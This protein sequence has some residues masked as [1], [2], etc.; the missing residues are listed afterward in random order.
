MVVRWV[1]APTCN[2]PAGRTTEPVSLLRRTGIETVLLRPCGSHGVVIAS[3]GSQPK[4]SMLLAVTIPMHMRRGGWQNAAVRRLRVRPGEPGCI[5][6]LA[7]LARSPAR[8]GVQRIHSSVRDGFSPAL[9]F[10]EFR[11][12]NDPFD[13]D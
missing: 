11:A 2:C 1:V 6:R 10:A 4:R 12:A 8:T 3:Q 13:D 9:R 7:L 5:H